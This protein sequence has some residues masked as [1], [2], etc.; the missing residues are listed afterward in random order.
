[1][2]RR[3]REFSLA[4]FDALH[5]LRETYRV[6]LD[7]LDEALKLSLLHMRADEVEATEQRRK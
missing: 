5:E 4:V 1:V 6:D 2:S 7:A 3:K